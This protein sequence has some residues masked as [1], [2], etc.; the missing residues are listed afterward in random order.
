MDEKNKNMDEK[1]RTIDHKEEVKDLH[2]SDRFQLNPDKTVHYG[3]VVI[4][5]DGYFYMTG[6]NHLE[7]DRLEVKKESYHKRYGILI[8][9]PDGEDGTGNEAGGDAK[10]VNATCIVIHQLAD[11]VRIKSLGGSGGMGGTGIA[12]SPGGD[13]GDA[14]CRNTLGGKGGDGS[15]GGRGMRGGNG[16]DG[17]ALTVRYTPENEEAEAIILLKDDTDGDENKSYGGSGGEGGEGGNGGRG[18]KGGKNG[19]G[20]MRAEHGKRGKKGSSGDRG[21]PGKD[22][23]IIIERLSIE[24]LS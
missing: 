3:N 14:V 11:S 13:G 19:D 21:E 23:A 10:G 6:G 22:T 18:G 15:Q 4:S 12:G 7:I 8:Q 2:I 1:N 20:K 24:R 9:G 5:G 17:S 16:S